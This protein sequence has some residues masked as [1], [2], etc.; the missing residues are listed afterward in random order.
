ME[1]KIERF[2]MCKRIKCVHFGVFTPHGS[3]Q[4]ATVIDMIKSEKLFGID[5]RFVDCGSEQKEARCRIGASYQ[6]IECEDPKIA[7]DADILVRHSYIPPD[8]EKLKI[9]TVMVCHGRPENSFLLEYLQKN[10]IYSIIKKAVMKPH[11][12]KFI[13]F[14]EPFLFHWSILIPKEKLFYVPAMIDTNHFTP[15]GQK[16]SF[17]SRSGEPNI[18]VADVWREDTTP[19]NVVHA[20]AKFI[21]NH[22]PEGK[23]HL[24]GLSV[25]RQILDMYCGFLSRKGIV[26]VAWSK[27]DFLGDVYRAADMVVTPHVIAT[28]IVR[29]ALSCGC[30]VVAGSGNPFTTYRADARNIDHYCQEINRCWW[31]ITTKGR[32]VVGNSVRKLAVEKFNLEKSGKKLK[33][34]FD[35]IIE[36]KKK[37]MRLL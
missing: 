27:I 18:V 11:Y 26:G 35:N 16:Y 29:E 2:I 21:T 28:R 4:F 34:L 7:F 5:A 30:P 1:R 22:A 32:E 10:P 6:G 17:G 3:G 9:P 23:V 25:K 8:I 19:Y 13:T 33:R 12:E 20:A 14:W 36:K 24:F 15:F 31:E 37:D